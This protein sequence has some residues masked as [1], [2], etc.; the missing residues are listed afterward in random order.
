MGA[1]ST[2]EKAPAKCG[3]CHDELSLRESGEG[4]NLLSCGHNKCFHRDCIERWLQRNPN[5]PVCQLKFALN[6]KQPAM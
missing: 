2:G 1:S 6:K 4:F 3:I 5:C